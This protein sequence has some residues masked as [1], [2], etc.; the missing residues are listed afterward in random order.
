M[1]GNEIQIPLSLRMENLKNRLAEDINNSGLPICIIDP[2]V[3]GIARE[4]KF[5]AKQSAQQELTIYKQ[6]IQSVVEQQKSKTN[7]TDE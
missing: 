7:N 5:T 2:I 6:Q 1:D 3:E 4:I